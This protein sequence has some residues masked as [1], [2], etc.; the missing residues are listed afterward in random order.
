MLNGNISVDEDD[1][2]VK[3]IVNYLELYGDDIITIYENSDYIESGYRAYNS[4]DE[5]LTKNVKVIS[6]LNNNIVGEYE[7]TYMLG[8]I[9]KTRIV[10][11]VEKPRVYTFIRLNTVDG[12]VDIRLKK[13]DVYQEPGYNVF[14]TSGVEL[15]DKVVVSGDVDTSKNGIYELVYSLVDEYGIII[16][17]SRK[18]TVIDLEINYSL[19]PTLYTSDDV[20]IN[21]SVDDNL[22][23]YM[24]LPDNTKVYSS[25]YSY[26]VTNNGNYLFKV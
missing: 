16:S 2:V 9:V 26:K 15:N 4:I 7:I 19:N 5:D 8:D 3:D 20:V 11:V 6:N 10:N 21:I 22:F 13:G 25:K 12:S 17:V 14:S 23:E 24:I 1:I 18:V